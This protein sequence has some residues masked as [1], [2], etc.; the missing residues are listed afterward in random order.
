V[1]WLLYGSGLGWDER[2][3]NIMISEWKKKGMCA[4]GTQYEISDAS[5]SDCKALVI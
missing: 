4:D 2:I 3:M 5:A 1:V